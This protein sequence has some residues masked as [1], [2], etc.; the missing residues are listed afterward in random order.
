MPDAQGRQTVDEAFAWD[1]GYEAAKEEFKPDP[2][3]VEAR[4]ERI[5]HKVDALMDKL[6]A[7]TL[8]L[9]AGAIGKWTA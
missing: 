4:V 7:M 1:R 8:A 2:D 5:E 9:R 6:A 3:E